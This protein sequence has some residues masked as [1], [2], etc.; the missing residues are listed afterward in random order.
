[1]LWVMVKGEIGESSSLPCGAL[2]QSVRQLV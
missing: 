2:I 1:M